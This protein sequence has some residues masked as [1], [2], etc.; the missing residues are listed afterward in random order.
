MTER[1]IKPSITFTQHPLP[2]CNLEPRRFEDLCLRVA[3]SK[4]Q[5]KN[6]KH[7]GRSGADEGRDIEG[8][9]ERDEK[10][11]EVAIQCK[12]YEKISGAELVQALEIFQSNFPNF[13]GE[14]W[15]MTSASVSLTA[16]K[17]IEVAAHKKKLLLFVIDS[18]A[19][20]SDVRSL[21]FLTEEFFSTPTSFIQNHL[22]ENMLNSI[23]A[24][25]R[26]EIEFLQE[27]DTSFSGNFLLIQERQKIMGELLNTSIISLK[28]EFAKLPDEIE[29]LKEI[30]QTAIS[31]ISNYRTNGLTLEDG[32]PFYKQE[33]FKAFSESEI[34]EYIFPHQPNYLQQIYRT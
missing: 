15:I 25:Q 28:S 6:P 17:Q 24:I 34:L 31:L 13:S 14:F 1:F 4:H 22:N 5:L 8:S 18:S 7:H 10:N 33:A 12:R 30:E 21:P 23:K 27:L 20:E 19:L 26:F 16:R 29:E 3:V 2:F 9:V 32:S 11:S